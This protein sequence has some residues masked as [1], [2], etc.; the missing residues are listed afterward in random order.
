[1]A[2][3]RRG[4]QDPTVN[5]FL[6]CN[7]FQ[8]LREWNLEQASQH[9]GWLR[10]GVP[11]KLSNGHDDRMSAANS[12]SFT[13]LT[14]RASQCAADSPTLLAG[15]HG[16]TDAYTRCRR[17]MMF[18]AGIRLMRLIPGAMSLWLGA[19]RCMATA[20][21]SNLGDINRLFGAKFPCRD[22]RII[23][24]DLILEDIV[25][26]PPIRRHT[27]ASFGAGTY[28]G[29]LWMTFQC[30]PRALSRQDAQNLFSRYI[31]RL[32]H[33]VADHSR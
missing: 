32:Q 28:A 4:R 33:T 16:E 5:D 22:G 8:T 12:V 1:M 9:D 11:V 27:H 24:G 10:I 30:D 7:L 14:R 6:L 3:R 25:G 20:V 15:I 23:A 2:I 21:L 18:L 13:F 31:D 29:R 19:N 26:T 17:A